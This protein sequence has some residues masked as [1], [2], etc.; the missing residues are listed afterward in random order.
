VVARPSYQQVPS[1]RMCFFV[2]SSSVE[3]LL[4]LT[5]LR[6]EEAADAL[7]EGGCRQGRGV[8]VNTHLSDVTFRLTESARCL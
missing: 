5:L 3:S 6:G 8:L 4:S 1:A 7:K 2:R